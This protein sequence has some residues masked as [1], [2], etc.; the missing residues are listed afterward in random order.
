MAEPKIEYEALYDKDGNPTDDP[1]QA[2][3]KR[4]AVRTGELETHVRSFRKGYGPSVELTDEEPE[5]IKGDVN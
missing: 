5:T 2:V 1:K 3:E 4:S